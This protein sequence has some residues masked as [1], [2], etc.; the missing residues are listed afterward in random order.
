MALGLNKVARRKRLTRDSE[1]VEE[2]GVRLEVWVNVEPSVSPLLGELRVKVQFEKES[3]PFKL[4][5]ETSSE[6]NTFR[7]EILI[8]I[9][10]K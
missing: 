4:S 2:V 10:G 7:G 6:T 5:G 8:D 1:V 3:V 9:I